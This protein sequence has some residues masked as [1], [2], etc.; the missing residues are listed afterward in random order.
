[1]LYRKIK[2]YIENHLK[3]KEDKILIIEGARQIGKSFIIRNVGAE[4]YPNFIE[5]NFVQDDENEGIFR[6]VHDTEEFYFKLSMIAGDVLNSYND[7][8]IFID[9]IQH[10]PQFLTL[11]KFFREDRRYRFICSGSLLGITL[12]STTSIPIGS[13]IIKKMY[14]LDFEEF[15]IANG[16][17]KTAVD[18]LL[19]S[20]ENKISLSEETHNKVLSLF[21][22]YLLVGGMPD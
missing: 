20:Y 11:L 13:V 10:Y 17:G 5:L 1:M 12:K 2:S 3:S 8:L 16:F 6:D 7:T 14:Q 19:K 15:L 9:E 18:H 4:L 22:R 21:K